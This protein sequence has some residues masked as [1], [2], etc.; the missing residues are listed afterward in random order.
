MPDK[1]ARTEMERLRSVYANRDTSG[2]VALY[3]WN[4]FTNAFVEYRRRY[5]WIRA[6]NAAGMSDLG[7]LRILDVGCGNGGWLRNLLEWGA[8]PELLHGIDALTD[9]ILRAKSL[10]RPDIDFQVAGAQRMPFRDQSFDIVAAS[11]VFSSVLDAELRANLGREMMRVTRDGGFIMV[12]DFVIS[13]PRNPDTVG[14]GKNEITR[15]FCGSRLAY[16]F[17]LTLVPPLARRFPAGLLWLA[18]MLE[19]VFPFLCS[20]RLYV[21]EK[22]G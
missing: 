6:F 3:R 12:Y 9:R 20:H 18:H 1:A 15:I 13:D 8:R 11:T 19:T 22:L 17:R 4:L 21:L 10:S 16:T 2:K 7:S 5:A 14:I